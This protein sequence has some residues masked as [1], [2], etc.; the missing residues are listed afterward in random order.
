MNGTLKKLL[1]ERWLSGAAIW[2]VVG[3]WCAAGLWGW[4]R[5]T[6]GALTPVLCVLN[7]A[8]AVFATRALKNVAH[9]DGLGRKLALGGLGVACLTFT[10]YSGKQALSLSEAARWA[11]YDQQQA[12]IAANARIDLAVAAVPEV[13]LSDEYGRPIGPLRTV[14]LGRQRNE[15]IGRL[16]GQRVRV[17]DLIATPAPRLPEELAWTFV[18]LI[19][20]LELL[21][22]W[23]LSEG[24]KPVS[25]R[26]LVGGYNPGRELV[27]M[28]RDRVNGA[29]VAA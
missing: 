1:G 3:A 2:A 23:A 26:S 29:A 7:V 15:K 5:A 16:D 21:G 8:A 20:A 12:A 18:L 4:D 27:K 9:A 25:L 10:G 22:F 14:E 19:E 17:G 24:G 11:P 6:D 13:P 28:R